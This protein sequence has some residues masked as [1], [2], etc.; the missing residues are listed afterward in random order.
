M[1]IVDKEYQQGDVGREE[2]NTHIIGKNE[3]DALDN[4][5]EQTC[6]FLQSKSEEEEEYTF[7]RL[8]IIKHLLIRHLLAH[9]IF[10]ITNSTHLLIHLVHLISNQWVLD[11]S[12]ILVSEVIDVWIVEVPT[13]NGQTDDVND[14]VHQHEA[15]D[16]K[17]I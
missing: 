9:H 3:L 4:I 16:S 15:H 12:T 8:K 14:K 2:H 10:Y 7:N 1:L 5:E 13:I 11:D 17:E 6:S